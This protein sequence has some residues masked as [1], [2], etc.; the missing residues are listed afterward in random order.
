MK[1]FPYIRGQPTEK[2]PPL[3]RYQPH[4]PSQIVSA[5][6][7]R[8]PTPG[9]V[10]EPLGNAPH[11]S[12]EAAQSGARVLVAANNPITRFILQQNA[13]AP[14]QADLKSSLAAL[15]STFKGKERLK[16][17]ILSLYA[18]ECPH[19][20]KTISAK[21]FLWKR[22][23]TVPHA[24]ICRCPY[25]EDFGE[26]P[27]TQSDIQ[28]AT[29]YQNNRLYRAR[30]LTRVAPPNDPIRP[31]AE[32]ALDVYTS[33][34][35]YAL[36]TI[37]NKFSGMSLSPSDEANLSAMILSA[38]YQAASLWE[39]PPASRGAT[40][41]QLTP[42]AKY[43]EN[44]IWFTLE[45]SVD[46]WVGPGQGIPCVL[47]PELPPT[48]GG[49]SV[50]SGPIRDLVPQLTE[51]VGAVMMA[52]PRPNLAYWTLSALWSG[53]LWGQKAAAPLRHIL[54]MSDLNWVWFTHALYS[55]LRSLRPLLEPSTPCLGLISESEEDFLTATTLAAYTAGLS[56]RGISLD[57]E[58]ACTQFFWRP[59]ASST[60]SA[61]PSNMR[62]ILRSAGYAQLKEIGEPTPALTLQAV[63]LAALDAENAF[64]GTENQPLEVKFQN[65][66]TALN[67]T[68]AYRQGFLYYSNVGRWWHEELSLDPLPLSDR[69]EMT[70]VK[71][72]SKKEKPCSRKTLEEE[73]YAAFPGLLTPDTELIQVCLDSYGE[74]VPPK[75]GNWRLR[76][77]DSPSAR[78]ADLEEMAD[79]IQKLGQQLHFR[80]EKASPLGQIR[81]FTWKFSGETAYTFFISASAILNKIILKHPDLPKNP[82]II[83]PGSRA[84][85]V[86]HKLRHNKPLA[87]A[88]EDNW[89]FLK[90]RQLRL[91]ASDG[92][93]TQESFPERL[94]QDQLTYSAP[95]LPLI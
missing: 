58:T 77:G 53:W 55:A 4:L 25:C 30:A 61:A 46:R 22:G 91:L 70:L 78:L 5:W 67:D 88:I 94:R 73:L 11:L 45:D 28:K 34:A 56:L 92:G 76:S 82:W 90:Y 47:W 84:N 74:E 81:V 19:C 60:L 31:H 10:L 86:S 93:I 52:L 57:A 87:D 32:K 89:G 51:K 64:A 21:A 13:H 20:G 65:L 59:R 38:C 80:T 63:G 66:K 23:A 62:S 42:P 26:Y 71:L 50:F 54:R 39:H 36:F 41:K 14:L 40:F 69:V 8:S 44:N 12:L 15:S 29:E 24:K 37:I 27:T 43:Q 79:L 33:R 72:L 1:R 48:E 17:H 16:P 68:F 3:E 35:V 95:Q 83:L 49:I 85:L 6:L 75:S 2:T 9:L 7:K 18:T